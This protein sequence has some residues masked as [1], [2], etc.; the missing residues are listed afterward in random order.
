MEPN[1]RTG[2]ENAL[3]AVGKSLHATFFAAFVYTVIGFASGYFI[4]NSE[5]EMEHYKRGYEDGIE[6]MA[7]QE[8]VARWVRIN[9][10]ASKLSSTPGTNYPTHAAAVQ[11]IVS[12]ADINEDGE[13]T[14]SEFDLF[15]SAN[16]WIVDNYDERSRQNQPA[17][18]E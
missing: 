18:G 14:G 5:A 6:A 17:E 15:A 16:P 4:G 13:L 12:S 3:I 1:E 9:D 2:F 8:D 10:L 7:E 11:F